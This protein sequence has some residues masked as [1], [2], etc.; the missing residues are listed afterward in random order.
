MYKNIQTLIVLIL[1]FNVQNAHSNPDGKTLAATLEIYAFPKSG[2]DT[3]QQSQDEAECYSWATNNTGSD[4]FDLQKQEIAVQEAGEQ[5]KKDANNV[6]RGAGAKGAVKGAA[7][8]VVIDDSRTGAEKG[9]VA[10]TVVARRQGRK[11]RKN[12]KKQAEKDTQAQQSALVEQGVKF[13]KAFS[14]CL[15]A[16][17]Y[18]VKF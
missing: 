8:G 15:E 13:K 4:P 7:L 3:Q 10:G 16:K 1:I 11:A 17:E 18:M 2:Q 6:G 12:A 9:A 14:T 5:A